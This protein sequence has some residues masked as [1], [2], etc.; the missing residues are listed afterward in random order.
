MT[1]GFTEHWTEQ[2]KRGERAYN[3][4]GAQN[5]IRI[6]AAV[7]VQFQEFK[8]KCSGKKQSLYQANKEYKE[9]K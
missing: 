8:N 2:V 3:L 4:K 7:F 6:L 5:Y 1:K 9:N